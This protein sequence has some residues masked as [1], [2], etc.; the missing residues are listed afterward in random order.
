MRFGDLEQG[1]V[2]ALT[3][4]LKCDPDPLEL[5]RL[6]AAGGAGR[7]TALL[8]SADL[9]TRRGE[10][11][12]LLLR[13]AVRVTARGGV[14]EFSALTPNGRSALDA[15]ETRLPGAENLARDGEM[16][17]VAYPP[18]NA[19]CS[20]GE[21]IRAA[22]PMD[23][24]RAIA[25]GWRILAAPRR[26]ALLCIGC[27]SYDLIDS[28]ES[29][30]AA[31]ADPLKWPDFEFWLPELLVLA[32]QRTAS[33]RVNAFVVGG[34]HAETAHADAVAALDETVKL[35]SRCPRAGDRAERPHGSSTGHAREPDVDLDDAAYGRLVSRMKRRITAGD[36]FQIVPSRSF[37][38]PCPDAV[39][40][41]ER[42]RALNPSP[43]M[44]LLN[45]SRGTL[46]GASP[47]T[48]L[49]V[50]NIGEGGL[51]VEIKPI[52]GTRPRGR[53]R[54]GIE[55]PDLD[56]RLEAEL[57][58]N[59][60]ELA[61]H[62]MLVDLARN[63]VARISRTGSRV[64][65]RL[66][67][68]DRYSHVMHLVSSVRGLLQPGLDALHAYVATMNMGTLVGAPK[69][70]AAELLR[71]AEA[72]RRGP[73]G[74]GVGYLTDDGSMDTCIVIRSAVVREGRAVIRAG[75]GIV[76]DSDPQAEAEETRRKADAV[77]QAVEQSIEDLADASNAGA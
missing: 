20:D 44:F 76:Y 70:R 73:Y 23:A 57:R 54:A 37:S 16:L 36:V 10:R 12:M 72:T 29:L 50:D 59:D 47:E 46:F 35:V 13:S 39:A 32:D 41:Y 48:A 71:G 18:R 3:R 56:A 7:D 58:L 31:A 38:S 77:L 9:S 8:E 27:F 52:A 11:S 14:V 45:G 43:Y 2:L 60:K 65:E 19:D 22:S 49:K 75:A 26:P 15:L 64:V 42:L 6:A 30:P 28:F 17:R 25:T 67:D 69:L 1:E 40:A 63:D 53:D 55:D 68:V 34:A 33:V 66:L 5:F 51:R 62:M 21:R 24:L 74:G 4:S 61:E